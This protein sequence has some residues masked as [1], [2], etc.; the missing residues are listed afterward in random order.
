MTSKRPAPAQHSL[1]D[2]VCDCGAVIYGPFTTGFYS[3][4]RCGPKPLPKHLIPEHIR[5]KP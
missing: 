1:L 2:C 4:R 3:C 5:P